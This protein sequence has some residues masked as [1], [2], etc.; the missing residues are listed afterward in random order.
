M[1][2]KYFSLRFYP[3]IPLNCAKS[4]AFYVVYSL[5]ENMMMLWNKYNY[6][7]LYLTGIN[8]E[9]GTFLFFNYNNEQMDCNILFFAII[10]PA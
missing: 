1:G 8:I 7:I 6:N 9:Y 10:A 5:K 4:Q 3:L 2:F